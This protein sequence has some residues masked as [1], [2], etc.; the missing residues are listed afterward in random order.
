MDHAGDGHWDLGTGADG[1]YQLRIIYM[2]HGHGDLHTN[3]IYKYSICITWSRYRNGAPFAAIANCPGAFKG[4]T[5]FEQSW[6]KD[7]M[8]TQAW[9]ATIMAGMSDQLIFID[10][11]LMEVTNVAV[12]VAQQIHELAPSLRQVFGFP[13]LHLNLSTLDGDCHNELRPDVAADGLPG[14]ALRG[15]AFTERTLDP[16]GF[17][18]HI[19]VVN[20]A[21]SALVFQAS[22]GGPAWEALA[23]KSK[24]AVAF[25]L[26]TLASI[27]RWGRSLNISSTGTIEPDWIGP[28]QTQIYQVGCSDPDSDWAPGG[29]PAAPVLPGNLVLHGS[30]EAQ[31]TRAVPGW[32]LLGSAPD[33]PIPSN[34]D[35][36][37]MLVS[38]TAVAAD[39]R[40]SLRIVVPT[41]EPLVFGLSGGVGGGARYWSWPTHTVGNSVVLRASHSYNVTLAVQASPVGTRVELVMGHWDTE[42]AADVT[43]QGSTVAS[44][45]PGRAEWSWLRVIVAVPNATA[46]N[47]GSALQLRITPHTADSFGATAWLDA[48]SVVELGAGGGA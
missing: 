28:G 42:S 30:M 20:T 26:F 41:P 9:L 17:C 8:L 3:S 29:G 46:T 10:Q 47:N 44:V 19:V 23:N 38:D 33:Q 48:V 37:A 45:E 15:E 22:L 36:R 4:G 14:G 2:Q 12:Q 6:Q 13:R 39:G 43:Y 5:Y 34:Q 18:A 7:W 21:M 32:M 27:P 25:R 11:G 35:T 24:A 31:A 40:H 16:G 1:A